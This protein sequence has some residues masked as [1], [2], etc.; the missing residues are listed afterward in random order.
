MFEQD[1]C[2]FT[3]K[4]FANKWK[5]HV[6]WEMRSGNAVRFSTILRRLPI[7]ERVLSQTLKELVA[8]EL[9]MRECF[10]EIPPRVEYSITSLGQTT[11]PLIEALYDW[12]RTRMQSVGLP[13]DE[14]GE[15]RHG[16]L[17]LDKEKTENPALFCDDS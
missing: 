8:D 17:P 4:C 3:I 14:V 7:T 12:G 16:Y 1:P 9:V 6:L 11:I 5:P 10:A 15:M 13:L 2:T